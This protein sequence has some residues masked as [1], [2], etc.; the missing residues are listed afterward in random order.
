MENDNQPANLIN[1]IIG[2][3]LAFCELFLGF[4]D[5]RGDVVPF[6]DESHRD[7]IHTVSCVFLCKSF[8]LKD[9]PEVSF[10]ITA[11]DFHSQSIRIGP[12]SDRIFNFVIK[13]RPSAVALKF[14]I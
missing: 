11:N 9:V 4:D 13:A 6:F 2:E 3:R 14:V 8:S 10:A 7:R 5:H 12:A 1:R